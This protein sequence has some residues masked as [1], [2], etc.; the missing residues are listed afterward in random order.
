MMR[1]S[2]LIAGTVSFASAL[3]AMGQTLTCGSLQAALDT[4][5]DLSPYIAAHGQ[6]YMAANA[7]AA[8]AGR[9]TVPE[10][11]YSSTPRDDLRALLKFC[12]SPNEPFLQVV[13]DTYG[14]LSRL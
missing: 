4:G 2:L 8:G 6:F 9:R 13:Q 12:S 11:G 5:G 1:R 3:P 7:A 14:I 10:W